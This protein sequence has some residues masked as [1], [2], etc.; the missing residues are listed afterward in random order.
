MSGAGPSLGA[1]APLGGSA[2]REVFSE[3]GAATSV[4]ASK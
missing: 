2:V 4:G 1:K 3:S